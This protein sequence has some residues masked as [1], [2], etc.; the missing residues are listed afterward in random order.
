VSYLLALV[1][2]VFGPLKPWLLLSWLSLP[3][4]IPVVKLVR[5]HTDGPSLN[6][7]LAATGRLQ[8]I[9]CLLLCAGI[10]LSR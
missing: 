8:L 1:T 7:A 6:G 10:L 9:F 2:W 5:T 3:L 4:A